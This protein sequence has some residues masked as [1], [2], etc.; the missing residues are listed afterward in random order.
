MQTLAIILPWL[1]FIAGAG[2]GYLA[3]LLFDWLRTRYAARKGTGGFVDRALFSPYILVTRLVVL[4]FSIVFALPCAALA[5]LIEGQDVLQAAD[6]TLAAAIAFTV[7][8]F[9]HA[10]SKPLAGAPVAQSPD[11]PIEQP[12][13]RV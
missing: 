6:A 10:Q 13:V 11:V 5:A 3:S 1:K 2:A 9:K 8:Q 12:E 4:V 7:S